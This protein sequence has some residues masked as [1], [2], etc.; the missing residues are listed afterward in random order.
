MRWIRV[1]LLLLLL[2]G[3]IA[4]QSVPVVIPEPSTVAQPS[5]TYEVRSQG[6]SNLHL[7]RIPAGNHFVIEPAIAK[8]ISPVSAFKLNTIAVINAGFFDPVNQKST[9]HVMIASKPVARPQDNDRLTQNPKLKPYLPKIFNRSEFRRYQ[10]GSETRYGIT[11]HDSGV[12]K[13][14]QWVDAIGAGPQ[15][16][17]KLTATEEGF[18]DPATGRD[19]IGYDQ[20]NARSAIA[21]TATGEV[22]FIM[23]E[24]RKP[25]GGL[26]LPQLA[27][28]LKELGAVS[29]MNLDGGTS[30]ALFYDGKVMFGK[31][32]EDGN[33]VGRLVKSVLVVRLKE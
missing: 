3:P 16:L 15:L 24:Q 11:F 18:W 7:V 28:V 10:C 19:A 22:L 21:L 26:S 17:P 30:S 6:N 20:P 23:V 13:D 9:S 27:T 12:L 4:C 29:A 31:R 32:D 25:G 2:G 8:E 5:V 14:C 1:A 33:L